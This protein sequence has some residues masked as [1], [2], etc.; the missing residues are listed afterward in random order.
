[1]F[2]IIGYMSYRLYYMANRYN[3]T[4]SKA[5]LI[6]KDGFDIPFR[7]QDYGFTFAFGLK[8]TLDPSYGYFTANFITS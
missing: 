8:N 6:K 2:A 7:P 5:T 3:P 1:M 4:V